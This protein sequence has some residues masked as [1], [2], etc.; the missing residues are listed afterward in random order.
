MLK[1][2]FKVN[3]P[4]NSLSDYALFAAV[5]AGSLIALYIVKKPRRQAGE[6]GEEERRRLDRSLD[7]AGSGEE[8]GADALLR[9]RL[10]EHA[11]AQPRRQDR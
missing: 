8:G 6:E 7:H 11:N 9:R 10:P 1:E 3:F 5:F 4:D 2:F